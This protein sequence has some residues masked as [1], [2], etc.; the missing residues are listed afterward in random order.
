MHYGIF[1]HL[2]ICMY[3]VHMLFNYMKV[4]DLLNQ[5]FTFATKAI[6][7]LSQF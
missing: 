1:S 5:D 6:T 3:N 2:F 4:H 7:D